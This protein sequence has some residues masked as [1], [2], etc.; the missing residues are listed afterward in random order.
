MTKKLFIIAP[1]PTPNGGLH[2]GHLSG[3][4]LSADIYSRVF[5][6]LYDEIHF[7]VST[8]D[9]QTYVDTTAKKLGVETKKLIEQASQDIKETFLQYNIKPSFFGVQDSKYNTYV[10][11]FYNKL[12][13]SGQVSIEK[14][15]VLHNIKNNTYP[16]ESF[17][18]GFCKYCYDQ[19]N[20]GICETCGFPNNGYDLLYKKDGENFRESKDKRLVIDLEKYRC[21]LENFFSSVYMRPELNVFVNKILSSA[22]PKIPLTYRLERGINLEAKD[23]SN[24]ALNVW[25]EMFPGHIYFLNK[26]STSKKIKNTKYVQFFGFDNSFFYVFLHKALYFAALKSGIKLPDVSEIYSNQ[27][28]YLDSSKFSTSKGHVIWANDLSV[29]YN[30][31]IIRLYLAMNAPEFEEGA[32]SKIHFKKEITRMAGIINSIVGYYNCTNHL[33]VA[34]EKKNTTKK[35]NLALSIPSP[36]EFSIRSLARESLRKLVFLDLNLKNDHILTQEV[37][38]TLVRLLSPFTVKYCSKIEIMVKNNNVKKL[39]ELGMIN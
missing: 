13:L 5:R 9:N 30:T 12:I 28:Y 38:E 1:P 19:S 31:D 3:P 6:H 14:I 21:E 32:F 24:Q 27:F 34:S 33:S 22:L 35:Y 39:P 7:C 4:Y 20:G 10:A 37:P 8:D 29:K 23:L 15:T 2:I 17:I 36:H 16:V 26:S 11:E 18:S 25:A